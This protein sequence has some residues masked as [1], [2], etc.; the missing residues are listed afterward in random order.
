MEN[1]NRLN[2]LLDVFV[3]TKLVTGKTTLHDR[4]LDGD[5]KH[6]NRRT[7]DMKPHC[8]LLRVEKRRLFLFRKCTNNAED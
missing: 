3:Y 1:L 2:F 6:R 5:S 7:F 8:Y 4:C